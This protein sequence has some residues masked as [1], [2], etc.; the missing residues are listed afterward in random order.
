MKVNFMIAATMLCVIESVAQE[1]V[2]D[3]TVTR[4]LHQNVPNWHNQVFL[5]VP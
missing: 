4:D 5:E 1:V 3:S 2:P